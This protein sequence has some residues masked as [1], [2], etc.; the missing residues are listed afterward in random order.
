MLNFVRQNS[1]DFAVDYG[2]I[3]SASIG[4]ITRAVVGLEA[5]GAD[6]S[7]ANPDFRYTTG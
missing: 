1:A 2:R 3:S 6:F 7:L 4:A 5:D